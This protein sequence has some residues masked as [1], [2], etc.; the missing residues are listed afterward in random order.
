MFTFILMIICV[1]V[2]SYFSPGFK[3]ESDGFYFTY[4]NKGTKEK[5]KLW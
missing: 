5:F 1:A 3:S 4:N 2:G